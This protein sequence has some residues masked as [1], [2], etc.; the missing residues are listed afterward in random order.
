MISNNFQVNGKFRQDDGT[1]GERIPDWAMQCLW[2]EFN[3]ELDRAYR[4]PVL[5]ALKADREFNLILMEYRTLDDDLHDAEPFDLEDTFV[6]HHSID[7][8]VYVVFQLIR[9]LP[10]ATLKALLSLREDVS[11]R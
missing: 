4:G 10:E 5:D 11:P 7:P 9:R 8:A 6:R 1:S 2:R 3:F